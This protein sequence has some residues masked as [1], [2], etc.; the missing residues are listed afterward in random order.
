MPNGHGGV[1]RFVSALML[2]VFLLLVFGYSRKE[3]LDWLVYG[4]YPLAAALGWRF[5]H[6][7]HLWKVT[8]YDGAYTTDE[9]INDAVWKYLVGS[10]VYAVLA[11]VAWYFLTGL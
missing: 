8:E 7:L 6:G 11:M 9:A 2:L 3:G 4:G 10:V 1:P 5:A